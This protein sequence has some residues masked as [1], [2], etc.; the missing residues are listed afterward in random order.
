M[1]GTYKVRRRPPAEDI[2]KTQYRTFVVERINDNI[3]A[4]QDYSQLVF[5]HYIEHMLQD[6]V[7][8]DVVWDVYRE[9]G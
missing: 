9:D 8:I 7:C 1:C 4:F 5:L 6:V 2:G 3:T